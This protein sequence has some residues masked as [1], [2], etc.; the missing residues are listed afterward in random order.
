MDG[1]K[2]SSWKKCKCG[3]DLCIIVGDCIRDGEFEWF[4]SMH[5]NNCGDAI[6][7]DG[8]GIFDLP[9]DIKQEIINRDG[10]W[11]LYTKYSK[12]KIAF[13]LTKIVH[14]PINDSFV[15]D[16]VVFTGTKLQVQWLLYKL[17]EK[18]IEKEC[19]EIKP[20]TLLADF[21]S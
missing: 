17:L 19:L 8:R 9:C 13:F 5:C 2:G 4:A 15:E 18:G 11:G 20:Y 21:E 10:E 16:N 14:E 7:M 1:P 6:E 3:N 12:S